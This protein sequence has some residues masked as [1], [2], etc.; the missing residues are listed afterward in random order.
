MKGAWGYVLVADVAIREPLLN[1]EFVA[2]WAKVFKSS[3]YGYW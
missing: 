2:K 3:N 1:D